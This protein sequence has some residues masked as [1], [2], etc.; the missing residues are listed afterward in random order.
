MQHAMKGNTKA[1]QSTQHEMPEEILSIEASPAGPQLDKP[2]ATQC[3]DEPQEDDELP[4]FQDDV[5]VE[6][7]NQIPEA[8]PALKAV[9][10]NNGEGP[11][12]DIE[13]HPQEKISD[14]TSDSVFNNPKDHE[15]P[16]ASTMI[17]RLMTKPTRQANPPLK[18]SSPNT[19]GKNARRPESM[20]YMLH[21]R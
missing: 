17:T 11:T 2:G 16:E 19:S 6:D 10:D 1:A 7:P 13:T 9:G 18:Q 4:S 21:L 15:N 14:S 3:K 20:L 5:V 8:T 12:T